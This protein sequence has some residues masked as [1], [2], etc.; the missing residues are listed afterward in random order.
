MEVEGRGSAPY[1][2]EKYDAC[3]LSLL[4]RVETRRL[5]QKTTVTSA[6]KTTNSNTPPTLAPTT[7][8]LLGPLACCTI[9]IVEFAA[10]VLRG[11]D[12]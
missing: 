8:P 10:A 1:G 6:A 12:C 11:S 9:G 2:D 4:E 3:L 5:R 7:R